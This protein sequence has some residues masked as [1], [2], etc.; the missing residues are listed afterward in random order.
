MKIQFKIFLLVISVLIS[1]TFL[2]Q[3]RIEIT[4]TSSSLNSKC[5]YLNILLSIELNDTIAKVKT[6][7]NCPLI[8]ASLELKRL[9]SLKDSLFRNDIKIPYSS[10]YSIK[11][12]K[13]DFLEIES[14]LNFLSN[15]VFQDEIKGCDGETWKIHYYKNSNIIYSIE[16]WSPFY[17]TEKRNLIPFRTFL[18]KIIKVSG[19]NPKDCG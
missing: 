6:G 16:L 5:A 7:R 18:H 9:D 19:I 3:S 14:Q 11:V 4:K 13:E 12:H 8:K 10:N 17:L 2:A 15:Y 1:S